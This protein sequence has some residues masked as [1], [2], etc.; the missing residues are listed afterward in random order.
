[1]ARFRSGQVTGDDRLLPYY[2]N[3]GVETVWCLLLGKDMTSL[4][5]SSSYMTRVQGKIEGHN[6]FYLKDPKA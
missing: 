6:S 2:I 3:S 1:M 4:L 5:I